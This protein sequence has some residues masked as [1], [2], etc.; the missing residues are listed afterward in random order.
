M[1]AIIILSTII[2]VTLYHPRHVQAETEAQLAF[3][4]LYQHME[5]R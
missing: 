3:S 4:G 1:R 5:R 2:T